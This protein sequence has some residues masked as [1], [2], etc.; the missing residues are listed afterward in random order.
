[1]PSDWNPP[2]SRLLVREDLV[3]RLSKNLI[4]SLEDDPVEAWAK[5]RI[6]RTLHSRSD[7]VA[8]AREGR[9]DSREAPVVNLRRW[10]R[11]QLYERRSSE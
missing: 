5:R 7:L 8:G 3:E 2:P 9:A 1:M 6:W 4:V 10:R 11:D